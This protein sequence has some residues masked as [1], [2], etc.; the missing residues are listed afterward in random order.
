MSYLPSCLASLDLHLVCR[1]ER[2]LAREDMRNRKYIPSDLI[3]DHLLKMTS[4]VVERMGEK[5][6]Y[7]IVV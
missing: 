3:R 7:A 6:L 1:H 2:H 4:E 5:R